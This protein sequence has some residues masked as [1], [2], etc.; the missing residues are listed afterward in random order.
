M[1]AI[2]ARL[3]VF[4][5]R[6]LMSWRAFYDA[7][8]SILKFPDYFGR[9]KD[10]WDDCFCDLVEEE[11]ANGRQVVLEFRWQTDAGVPHDIAAFVDDVVSS[12]KLD[13]KVLKDWGAT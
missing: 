1:A 8:E 5:P 3:F 11:R 12:R 2:S 10:A 13:V 9:N 7:S 4:E 6:H